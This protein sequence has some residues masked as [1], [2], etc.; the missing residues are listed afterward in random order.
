MDRESIVLSASTLMGDEVKNSEG[1]DL[2]TLEEIMIDIRNGRIAYAVLSFGGFLGIGE[3][4]FALPWDVMKLDTEEEVFLL[5]IDKKTLQNG[6][7]F[8]KDDWP[9]T[10]ADDDSW[11]ARVYEYYECE[12]YWR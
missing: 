6:P 1:E 2:G 8:D 9:E 5:D 3:K 4:L 10:T 11:L 7:G 12:P